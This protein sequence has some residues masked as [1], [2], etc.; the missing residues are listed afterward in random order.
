MASPLQLQLPSTANIDKSPLVVVTPLF[1]PK[2]E[3]AASSRIGSPVSP[4][5]SRVA[6]PDLASRR[7]F[8]GSR[9]GNNRQVSFR[10]PPASDGDDGYYGSD[11]QATCG[12][13]DSIQ[14]TEDEQ[15]EQLQTTHQQ[16]QQQKQ[17][18]LDQQPSCALPHERISS[19]AGGG[20]KGIC[21]HTR[22]PIS[23]STKTRTAT[24]A[25]STPFG[26]KG[27]LEK[28]RERRARGEHTVRQLGQGREMM[29]AL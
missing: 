18:H 17:T 6:S 10:E 24:M 7:S 1:R 14:P 28:R 27:Y 8:N 4:M 20:D 11:R 2:N 9:V 12:N 16:Q 21:H 5:K 13:G 19:E 22:E 29:D 15:R 25:A 23:A 26:S 3:G